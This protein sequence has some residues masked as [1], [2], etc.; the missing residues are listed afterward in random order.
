M[1]KKNPHTPAIT[2][3]LAQVVVWEAI[4]FWEN[5]EKNRAA[6]KNR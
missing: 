5:T 1:G 2:G 3:N 4:V 6:F